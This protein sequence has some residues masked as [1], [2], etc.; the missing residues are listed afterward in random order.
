MKL[1]VN[2]RYRRALHWDNINTLFNQ[3][4]DSVPILEY[5]K[6]NGIKCLADILIPAQP[7]KPR[8]KGGV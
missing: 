3:Y 5:M 8:S 1:S 7:K 2:E 6:K 4:S